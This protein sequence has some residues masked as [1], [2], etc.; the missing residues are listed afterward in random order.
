MSS[1]S[2]AIYQHEPLRVPEKWSSDPES[3]AF[4]AQIENI[5]DDIYAWRN[6]V[7]ITDF[8]DA[9]AIAFK[10]KTD[11]DKIISVINASEESVMISADKVDNS[12]QISTETG[13]SVNG[14]LTGS[15]GRVV[16]AGDM[17]IQTF[18]HPSEI[19]VTLTGGTTLEEIAAH[20][21][22]NSFIMFSP[23]SSAT[24]NISPQSHRYGTLFLV[25][26]SYYRMMATWQEKSATPGLWTCGVYSD[27]GSTWTVGTWRNAIVYTQTGTVT[28]TIATGSAV[29]SQV[30]TFPSSFAIAPQV[31]PILNTSFPQGRSV[32]LDGSVSPSASGFKICVGLAANATSN[33]SITVRWYAR[34]EY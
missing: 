3:R 14:V 23:N 10:A 27:D 9:L 5:L 28:L 7:K 34:E 20:L 29:A 30:V 8:S 26:V 24:T 4:V 13:C 32:S 31:V 16:S 11:S 33:T 12:D 17:S 21:P 22:N 18:K 19:G 25:R 1:R 15:N 2:A 6:R